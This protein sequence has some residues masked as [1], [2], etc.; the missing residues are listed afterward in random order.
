MDTDIMNGVI[1]EDIPCHHIKLDKYKD[2]TVLSLH[3]IKG[4]SMDFILEMPELQDIR[5]YKCYFKDHTALSKLTYL[6]KLFIN[7]IATKEEQT[8]DY[9]ADLSSLEELIIGYIQSFI[10]FPN[11]SN[12]QNLHKLMIMKCKNLIEI[13]SIINIPNLNEFDIDCYQL[14]PID[15]EFIMQKDSI[16]RVNAQFRSKRL[17]E[18]FSSLLM[19]YNL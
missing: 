9:I 11:L 6:R 10:K 3:F 5:M 18:E 14:R 19:K 12:L 4:I 13:N 1:V 17:K 16:Q 2:A 7:G 8:F 15:L